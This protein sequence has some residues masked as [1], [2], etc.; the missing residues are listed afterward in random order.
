[1]YQRMTNGQKDTQSISIKE[2]W[3]ILNIEESKEGKSH[4]PKEQKM[5][6]WPDQ[7]PATPQALEG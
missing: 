2:V 3:E 5:L 1:M 4:R 7:A 6:G